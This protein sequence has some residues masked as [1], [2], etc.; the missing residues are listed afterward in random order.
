MDHPENISSEA[1]P[2]IVAVDDDPA[3]LQVIEA[4]LTKHDYLVKTALSGAEAFSILIH[5]IPAVL[6]LDVMM[7]G[8][9]G[10]DVC[11]LVKSEVRLKKVPVVF[12]T[13]KGAPENFKLGHDLGAVIY[14]T[15][16][17]QAQKLLHVVQMLCPIPD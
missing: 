14:M 6:I 3:V 12:L 11:R 15:K 2:V 9:S 4:L 10:Y 17:F 7:P 5:E 13:S 16:P 1:R 8:A